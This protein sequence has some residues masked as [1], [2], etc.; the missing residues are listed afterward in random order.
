M[1]GEE[2]SQAKQQL[3]LI[4]DAYLKAEDVER[5]LAACDFAD[6]AHSGITRKSGEPYVLHPIAVC[7]IL[8]HMRLDAETLMA[9]LLHDVI[10]DTEYTKDDVAERFGRTVSDLV[11]GVTKL[12]HSSDKQFN[13]AASFRKILQATLQDPRVIIIKLADR[14]HNMT[15]LDAL[16]PDK[17]A[18]IAQET[19]DIFVPMARIVGMNEMADNLELL[20][21]QNLDLDMYNNV[22][23][24]L[25]ESKPKRCE[26]QTQWEKH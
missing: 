16:R 2:V 21:Y 11:D 24:A 25:L 6:L 13:K 12:T 4:I 1:P 8:A 9:A 18:R 23:T 17:R 3:K 14:Y 26:Y 15:T 10:E 5:V 20:C 7:C 19:L 22:Q